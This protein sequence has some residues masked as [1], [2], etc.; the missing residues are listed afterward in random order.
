MTMEK[1][2]RFAGVSITVDIPREHMFEAEGNLAPFRVETGGDGHRFRYQLCDRLDEPEGTL[3]AALPGLLV[4]RDGG[5]R[6]TYVGTVTSGW[7]NAYMRAAHDGKDHHIQVVNRNDSCRLS[8]KV[9][10][11]SIEIE[12]LVTEAE[13]FV[14]HCAFVAVGD[15]AV[16]FTA[17]SGVG[18]STQAELWRR[19]R[20][21]EIVNGDR[22]VVRC[23]GGRVLASGIPFS[24]SSSD[25]RN[26]ELEVAAIVYLEQAP[27][28]SIRRLKG[29]R[30]FRCI[31]EGC[32]VNTWE[33]GQMECVSALAARAAGA[34]PVYHMPCT[35][36]GSAVLALE[37][38]MKEEA[39]GN[40]KK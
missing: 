33:P 8:P 26:R 39:Y 4:Y 32:S 35:P 5:R 2:Y 15:R 17:P 12:R 11:N 18:K 23:A 9:V 7:E 36:D 10:L 37:N 16:L 30:A 28:T 13:G 20:S 34:V 21:A 27:V 40:Q 25:C 31:W 1:H 19:L 14:L 38:A 29:Y 24:G 6:I 3:T 22:A